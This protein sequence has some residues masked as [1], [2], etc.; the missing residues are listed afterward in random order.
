MSIWIIHSLTDVIFE[1]WSFVGALLLALESSGRLSD[2][3]SSN[4]AIFLMHFFDQTIIPVDLI[5]EMLPDRPNVSRELLRILRANAVSVG[6]YES[7]NKCIT[8]ELSAQTEYFRRAIRH[9]EQYYR[10]K[11]DTL[12]K[13]IRLMGRA[14]LN[15]VERFFGD[16]V[17]AYGVSSFRHYYLLLFL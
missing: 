2:N 17:K 3:A 15:L 16:M 1:M 10:D 13:R 5:A 4:H 14:A 6:D 11:Y 9:Q 7:Q 12:W 8:F